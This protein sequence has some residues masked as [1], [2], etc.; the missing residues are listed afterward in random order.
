MTGF[1]ETLCNYLNQFDIK[2]ART[3]AEDDI[4]I[5]VAP[6]EPMW[7]NKDQ[8]SLIEEITKTSRWGSID[9]D[10]TEE[11]VINYKM[12]VEYAN[13]E[14]KFGVVRFTPADEQDKAVRLILYP[15]QDI[16]GYFKEPTLTASITEIPDEFL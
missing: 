16:A 2:I 1:Y 4:Y 15:T 7:K 5:A 9:R 12:K 10:V 11:I 14:F 13:H 6:Q 3:F 8:N